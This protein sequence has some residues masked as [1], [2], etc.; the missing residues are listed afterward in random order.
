MY[1]VC[2]GCGC[3]CASARMCVCVF[4]GCACVRVYVRAYVRTCV[5]VFLSNK[6]AVKSLLHILSAISKEQVLQYILT[7][8]DDLLQVST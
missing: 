8:I 3:A 7:L 1:V 4:H 6:Q 5:C 2:M